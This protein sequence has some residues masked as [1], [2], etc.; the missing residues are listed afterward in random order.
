MNAH[1][2]MLNKCTN[3]NEYIYISASTALH[4]VLTLKSELFFY[5]YLLWLCRGI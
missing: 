3:I 2:R 4:L 5:F 1:N